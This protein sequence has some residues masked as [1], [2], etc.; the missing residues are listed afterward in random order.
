MAVAFL[1]I[2]VVEAAAVAA[3]VAAAVA[4]VAVVILLLIPSRL[5]ASQ[6]LRG[7]VES[8]GREGEKA[9]EGCQNSLV[10]CYHHSLM[11]VSHPMTHLHQI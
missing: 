9:S 4:A 2:V 1:N 3:E 5:N 6:K 11:R 7:R 8:E 10:L